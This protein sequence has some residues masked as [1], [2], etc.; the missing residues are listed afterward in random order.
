MLRLEQAVALPTAIPGVRVIVDLNQIESAVRRTLDVIW[1]SASAHLGIGI[2]GRDWRAHDL[3]WF[4]IE[5]Q[6]LVRN[7]P[8]D[9][10]LYYSAP[11]M[12]RQVV[13]QLDHSS[14]SGVG[15]TR[16]HARRQ[17]PSLR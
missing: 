9:N 16:A 12:V 14:T 11:N 8:A 13:P 6:V 1:S 2:R 3:T 17:A 15:I 10:D 7:W 5:C 4:R